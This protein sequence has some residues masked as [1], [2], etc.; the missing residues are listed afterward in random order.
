MKSFVAAVVLTLLSTGCGHSQKDVPAPA[1]NT[2]ASEAPATSLSPRL[3]IPLPYTYIRR[4][5]DIRVNSVELSN[6]HVQVSLTLK[7]TRN[8]NPEITAA[9]LMQVHT[10]SGRTFPFE[11]WERAGE[12][13]SSPMIRVAAGERFSADLFYQRTSSDAMD[14]VEIQFPSGKWWSSK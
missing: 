13:Q 7:E 8:E 2:D 1:P 9:G 12:K 3:Q 14:P 10:S 4:G 11:R 5:V 6:T